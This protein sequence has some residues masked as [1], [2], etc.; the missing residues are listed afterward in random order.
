MYAA[1]IMVCLQTVNPTNDL[2]CRTRVVQF[3]TEM[4]CMQ[5]IEDLQKQAL[6]DRFRVDMKCSPFQEKV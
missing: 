3:K 1:I 2:S 6:P 5:Y 4:E